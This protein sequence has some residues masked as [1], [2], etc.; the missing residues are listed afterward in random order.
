M[1]EQPKKPGNMVSSVFA[2]AKRTAEARPWAVAKGA[3]IAVFRCAACGA[4]GEAGAKVGSCAYCG[5]EM[6]EVRQE[7][8][9]K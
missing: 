1:S 4:P 3:S 7:E 5:G 6:V 9:Q 2:N 8:Q